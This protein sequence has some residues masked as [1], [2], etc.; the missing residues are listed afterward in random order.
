MFDPKEVK[1]SVCEHTY[2]YTGK[3]VRKLVAANRQIEVRKINT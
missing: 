3:G 2:F 1:K